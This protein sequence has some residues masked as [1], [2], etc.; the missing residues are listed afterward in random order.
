MRNGLQ[1]AHTVSVI[2]PCRNAE[3]YISQA[4]DSVILQD[5]NPQV[6]VV[7]DGSE[8]NS[9]AIV[10]GYSYPITL[11]RIP[12]RGLSNARNT[13]LNQAS[14]QYI[15]FL[16]AD[17]SIAPNGLRTL[18][19]RT[20]KSNALFVYGGHELWDHHMKK[21]ISRHI[22]SQNV[23]TLPRIIKQE[24]PLPVG[25]YLVSRELLT[26]VGY[27]DPGLSA[28]EDWDLLR[29]ILYDPIKIAKVPS[30]ILKYRR[31]L[32]TLSK[33]PLLMFE[34]ALEVLK[35]THSDI[36]IDNGYTRKDHLPYEEM[37]RAQFLYSPRWVSMACLQNDFDSAKKIVQKIP[38]PKYP[39]IGLFLANFRSALWWQ[40]RD[41]G[42]ADSCFLV[43]CFQ[44]ACQLFDQLF[45][46]V[47]QKNKLH[48]LAICPSIKELLPIPGPNK[49]KRWFFFYRAGKVLSKADNS[50]FF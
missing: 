44:S 6:I 19:S 5:I 36:S 15:Y 50:D 40:A 26:K 24:N 14:G 13:G 2:I 4:L 34:N 23:H 22:P 49:L 21:M 48:S 35:R 10:S 47:E 28:C 31:H 3:K 33:R 38:V 1:P 27:F 11:L 12:H 8:D 25:T 16:D 29:R 37:K 9:S 39:D 43:N 41:L 46:L 17:D 42:I 18:L 7:D 32:N 45:I 20:Q 30:V